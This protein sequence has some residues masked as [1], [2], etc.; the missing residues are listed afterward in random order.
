M[1]KREHWGKRYVWVARENGKITSWRNVRGSKLNKTSAN[2]LYD[3]NKTFHRNI[4]RETHT[5][6]KTKVRETF[7]YRDVKVKNIPKINKDESDEQFNHREKTYFDRYKKG[8]PE[9]IGKK[10]TL[11]YQVSGDFGYHRIIARSQNIYSDDSH[12]N[13]RKQAKEEA[14][15]SFWE[16]ISQANAGDYDENEGIKLADSVHNIQE[17]WVYYD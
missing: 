2:K 5:N 6:P 7:L 15:S 13:T 14:W 9:H 11:Q 4:K 16:K 10:R 1:A 8:T 17:G 12:Y 3:D